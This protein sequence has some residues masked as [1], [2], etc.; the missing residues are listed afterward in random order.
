MAVYYR[1]LVNGDDALFN[2]VRVREDSIPICLEKPNKNPDNPPDKFFTE[3]RSSY[4]LLKLIADTLM[5]ARCFFEI[6]RGS[7]AQ[8]HYVDIDIALVDD[9]LTEKFPHSIEEKVAIS[10][11]ICELYIVALL[12]LKPEISRNDIIICNS[13]SNSKR[14]FHIIVDRWFFPSATQNKELFMQC[15][16]FIPLPYRKYFDERMYKNVQ[17]FRTLFSTKCG[18]NRFKKIDKNSTWK[19]EEQLNS[20]EKKLRELFYASLI[21]EVTCCTMLSFEY[22]DRTEFVPSR[23]L[24]HTEITVVYQHF[25]KF[26]DHGKFEFTDPKNSI[27]PL[28][29]RASYYCTV[30]QRDHDSENPYLYVTF[31]N[32]LYFNCRRNDKSQ[33]IAD[34]STNEE[35]TI[36]N[37]DSTSVT[38]TYVLPTISYNVQVTNFIDSGVLDL[39]R[40]QTEIKESCSY[41][42]LDGLI[43]NNQQDQQ[44]RPIHQTIVQSIRVPVVSESEKTEHHR[45]IEDAKLRH[46]RP[47]SQK[48]SVVSRLSKVHNNI[49][50]K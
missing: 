6:I 34:L 19:Y 31:D 47:P 33:L 46:R 44:L 13:H 38:S 41:P 49:A 28:R 8:K 25:K 1:K 30:C 3:I 43:T 20:D 9:K 42:H 4:Q 40:T 21:T 10:E 12:K 35:G 29:R 48:E 26:K 14:S 37:D 5:M 45:I 27:I 2:N 16:E 22:K 32:K 15:M 23:N 7:H 11:R 18:K 39:S 36:I 50:Y 17:Q 24:D